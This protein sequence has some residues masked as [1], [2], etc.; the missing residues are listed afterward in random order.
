MMQSHSLFLCLFTKNLPTGSCECTC[1]H[2]HPCLACPVLYLPAAS[3][4]S[5][6]LSCPG[7]VHTV[8][9]SLSLAGSIAIRTTCC[10]YIA[11]HCSQQTS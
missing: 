7:D 1:P 2:S 8:R 10:S 11:Y 4:P 3:W 5:Q 9:T 6:S